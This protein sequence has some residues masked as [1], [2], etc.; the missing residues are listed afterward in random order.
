MRL[1]H[2]VDHIHTYHYLWEFKKIGVFSIDFIEKGGAWAKL[3]Y[4]LS[5]ETI[6]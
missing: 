3:F 5:I 4:A 6:E 1:R 2:I